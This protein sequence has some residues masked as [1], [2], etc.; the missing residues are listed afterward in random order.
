MS[1]RSGVL[2]LALLVCGCV[3]A[4]VAGPAESLH[5]R[6]QAL[7][8]TLDQLG[9][10][11]ETI[12]ANAALD[13]FRIDLAYNDQQ[14]TS[15]GIPPVTTSDLTEAKDQ[16]HA[17]MAS[18][19]LPLAADD[20]TG[21]TAHVIPVTGG[22]ARSAFAETAPQ[23]EV[24]YRDALAGYGTLTAGQLGA[25]GHL[26]PGT[27]AISVTEPTAARFGL[28]P[29]S[30]LRMD[31]ASLVV[32]GILRARNLSGSFWDTDPLAAAPA[33]QVPAKGRAS[34]WQG[35]VFADPDQLDAFQNLF[36]QASVVQ[37][38]F[39]LTLRDLN[40]DQARA[41]YDH[42]SN[43]NSALPGLSGNLQGAA[44]DISIS[45]PLLQPLNGFLQTQAAVLT[46]LLLLFVSLIV[47]GAAVILLAGRMIVERREDELAMLRARGASSRQVATL[48]ARGA[49]AAAIPAA[50]AGIGI[51]VAVSPGAGRGA[52]G[53]AVMG[54]VLA[55]GTLVIAVA[56]PVLIGAWR[57][58]RPA[59]A[60]NPALILSADTGIR[61]F[62]GRGLRRVIVEVTVVLA[63]VAG[64]VVLR[65]QGV[66]AGNGT[67]WYLTVAPALAAIPAMSIVLRLYPA[68]IRVLLRITSRRAG[69]T[70][71]VALAA[72]ARTSLATTGSAFAL[73]LA[74]TLAAFAGMVT[75]A[76]NSGQVAASWQ[77]TGGDAVVNTAI[78]AVPVTPAAEHALSA[79]PGVQH[80][81][82]VWNTSWATPNGQT[83][84]VTAVNPAQYA[85]LTAATPFP[86]IP[87][88][89]LTGT[90]RPV[91]DVLAS[92]AAA[93]ELGTGTTQLTSA[94]QMG[95]IQVHVAGTVSATP[96]QPGGGIFIVMPLQTLPGPAGTPAPNLILLTGANLSR[97]QLAATVTRTLSGATL[98]YRADTL[99]SL[100]HSPL[101]HGALLLMLL[102]VAAAAGFGLLNLILGLALG[103]A[104]RDLTYARLSVMGH[105]YGTR[106]ALTETLPAVLAAAIAGLAC[107]LALPALVG[108]ALDLS[109][110]TNSS[111]AVSLR[112]GLTSLGLPAAAMLLLAVA[113]LI[114]QTR[115]ARRRG[116]TGL[117]R[118]N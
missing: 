59:P 64:L 84:S 37:W 87:V 5:I 40:A 118:A 69:A 116:A 2:S 93:A 117:L 57:H 35:A 63:A 48:L 60:A 108:D 104:E 113:A 95:P 29:G 10:S 16:L 75:D 27:L 22:Y 66:S 71:Y 17:G 31:H 41:L 45:A 78:T 91:I 114:A 11:A 9:S 46:V 1:A 110:F 19:P 86:R 24:L 30:V 111:A 79:V 21:I 58:R 65:G 92:P 47:V 90:R 51:A 28:R 115:L 15:G 12:E 61:W 34:Y 81:A 88:S 70:S 85:A 73:V 49:A 42:L 97:A 53:S 99:A 94:G 68:V 50:A 82:A 13:R 77:A 103:A 98:A 55:A 36:S 101:Q 25:S 18:L 7:H 26:P 109:V 6:T 100:R 4:A 74:L 32:T 20:W 67:N 102:T 80:E 23:L 52:G 39:P 43:I 106:L 44:T 3:F 107:A 33:L 8:Q 54:W 14:F 96:A 105:P 56:G 112:P 38:E 83:V 72:S 76:I 62:P 89:E